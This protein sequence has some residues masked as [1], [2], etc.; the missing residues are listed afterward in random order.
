MSLD[1]P[2]L[3]TVLLNH[4]FSWHPNLRNLFELSEPNTC[5][6]LNIRTTERLQPWKSSAVTLIGDA[7]HTM[8][9]GLGVGANTALLD[10]RI[11]AMALVSS[12][13]KDLAVITAV[14]KYEQQMHT[15][16][17]DRVEK[18]PERFNANDAIYKSGLQGGLA[19]MLMRVGMRVVNA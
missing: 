9:P 16:A 17:R 6:P 10:A 7:I 8:T 15:Y 2:S 13:E 14:A 18:S 19:L 12:A 11:L 1:G 4:T 3:H 5:F